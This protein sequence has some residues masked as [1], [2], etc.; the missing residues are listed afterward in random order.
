VKRSEIVLR[1]VVGQRL[2]GP[3]PAPPGE[4]VAALGAVQA[5][6]HAGG[7]W[8]IGLRTPDATQADVTEAIA[9]RT[10]VRTWPMRRTLHFVAAE[11]VRWMLALLA[12]REIA[13]S[14]YR[15]RQLELDDAAFRR[16]RAL[17]VRELGRGVALTRAEMYARF[18]RAGL[19]PAGQRG[20]HILARLAQEGVI[21]FGPHRDKQ[22]TFTLLDA[23]VP[24]ARPLERE[25]ALARLA[26]RYFTSHGPATVRDFA[27]WSGLTMGDARAGVA[28][29]ASRLAS[30]S[31]D[32]VVHW[33]GRGRGSGP[34]RRA[35]AHLLPPWDEY[36]VAYRD[37][38]DAVANLP[39]RKGEAAYRLLLGPVVV[40]DGGAIGTWRRRREKDREVV[41]VRA[42]VPLRAA[43]RTAVEEA[44]ARYARFLA[45]RVDL[46]YEKTSTVR[47][48]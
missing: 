33:L 32:G 19:S 22:P 7:L 4:V 25:E 40:L 28:G 37:R 30:D 2:A 18:A 24:A 48:E 46:R 11:D 20:I 31:I 17:A 5:Q 3:R 6:D 39:S 12:P 26:E 14:A 47:H 45:R 35:R 16:S 44:G 1:R 29:A 15:L 23:W 27:W 34:A 8:A 13:A 42:F 41:M 38:Q 36:V 43:E 10:I 21:C 9:T